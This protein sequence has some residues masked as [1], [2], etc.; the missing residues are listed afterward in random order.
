MIRAEHLTKQFATLTAIDDVSFEV[1]R[2]EVVGFLGP[3]GAGK[4]TTMRILGGIFPPTSGRAVVAG[5]DVVTESLAA[6]RAVGYLT[7]RVSLYLDMTVREYLQYVAELKG[8]QRRQ[9][10]DEVD[11]ALHACSITHVAHR[12]VGTLSK[13]YR[14]R[15][16]IAQA[17]VGRPQVLIL[18]EPTAGLDPE[19]VAEMRHLIRTFHG[20]S[21]VILSTHIL[22][23]V[24]AICDRVIIIDK[25]RVLAVDT[26]ANL[27][28]RLRRTSQIHVE[29]GAPVAAVVRRLEAVPGVVEITPAVS[30][31]S[32]T[33]SIVV[34]TE[35]DRDLRATVAAVV[36][37][38]GWPL[39]EL[40][41]VTLTLEEIF[42]RLVSEQ[43]KDNEER[44][45]G[46]RHLPA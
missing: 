12:L 6:R 46:A 30:A 38:A 43:K 4:S 19:Q 37:E 42:L 45:E 33:V 8:L 41:P 29:V 31:S 14:Q 35:K 20:E 16:G 3:N 34:A 9:R 13:G 27:N 10:G 32:D 39:L 5:H 7:E 40:R 17:L 11:R 1:S 22:S 24:E 15:V 21:T 18:D 28:R 2:G 44:H 23:E 25:G 26:T 36:A